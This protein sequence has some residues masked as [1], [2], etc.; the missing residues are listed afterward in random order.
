MDYT[1]V[2]DQ[3]GYSASSPPP[4]HIM[5]IATY[6]YPLIL[7]PFCEMV[8]RSKWC[9]DVPSY[10]MY[11]IS[12]AANALFVAFFGASLFA[13]VATYIL[14]RRG[15]LFTIAM[16]LGVVVEIIGYMG[17]VMSWHN[18]WKL[19][20]FLLQVCC[21]TIAPVFL[22]AGL[23]LCL[24]RVVLVVG[25][26]ISRISPAWYTQIFIPCDL[27]SLVLQATGGGL[28]CHASRR[29][30]AT[31]TGDE[32]M[33]AG[34]A[35]QVFTMAVYM[36][37]AA[38][39]AIRAYRRR[40]IEPPAGDPRMAQLHTSWRFQGFLAALALATLCVFVRSVF[41]VVELSGGWSGNLMA[42]QDLFITFE[43]AMIVLAVVSLNIFHPV[44]CHSP[45]LEDDPQKHG[46]L[47]KH[48]IGGTQAPSEKNE[49][50]HPGG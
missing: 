32:I 50:G 30:K 45:L 16:S 13:F 43:G 35:F 39:F 22:A 29:G 44:F 41:R 20:Y 11:K 10:Y 25:P 37:V 8:P 2:M 21:L 49:R 6:H 27:V 7:F 48:K 17:R 18:P 15:F 12:L 36:L 46:N 40:S 24:R 23:Y 38:D 47:G 28:A 4:D 42:R 33:I 31:K 34:L 19:G 5:E 3:L 26:E 14:R 9:V 1:K